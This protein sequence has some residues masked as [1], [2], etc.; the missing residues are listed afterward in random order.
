MAI[1]RRRCC[2]G[3]R[4][5]VRPATVNVLQVDRGLAAGVDLGRREAATVASRARMLRVPCGRWDPT[6][7]AALS[8]GGHG[9]LVVSG[10]LLRRLDVE[11][12]VGAELLGTADCLR[13]EAGRSELSSVSAEA[14]WRVV[15]PLRLAVLDRPWSFR[16]AAYRGIAIELTARGL[17]RSRRLANTLAISQQPRLDLRLHM[18]LWELADRYGRVGPDGVRVPVPITHELLANLAAARRPSVTMALRRLADAALVQRAA[19]GGW[20]LHGDP[21]EETPGRAP[22]IVRRSAAP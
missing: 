22:A 12:H 21:P 5:G 8:R 11:H 7:A 14:S 3:A 18:L 9:L 20:L 4:D 10:L 2:R 16:M 6:S 15:E 13:P 1:L 19:G 17:R